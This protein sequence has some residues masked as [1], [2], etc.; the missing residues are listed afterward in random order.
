MQ[1]LQD[2]LGYIRN[3]KST[4]IYTLKNLS[5]TIS[6]GKGGVIIAKK[7]GVTR[8]FPFNHICNRMRG[9]N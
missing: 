6:Y 7:R 9:T 8:Y 3:L 1:L 4:K 2:N 5:Y